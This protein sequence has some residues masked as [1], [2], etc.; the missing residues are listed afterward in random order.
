VSR[1]AVFSVL[2]W[3]FQLVREW[4]DEAGHEIVMLVTRPDPRNDPGLSNRVTSLASRD[5]LIMITPRVT[6]SRSALLE[7][8]IDL[9]LIFAYNH[10]PESVAAAP[11]HGTVN[12]HPALLPD[13]RGA[14]A[15]R[16]LFEGEQRIGATLHHVVEEF[17]AGP[18]LAQS[19]CD[20]PAVVD[21][22]SVRTA[23]SGT[24]SAV[25]RDGVP[26][27]LADEPGGAQPPATAKVSTPFREDEL[28]LT[29]NI[30]ARLLQARITALMMGGR[31]PRACI[32]E[33]VQ[34]IRGVRVLD[35]LES[36]APGVVHAT[37][38]RAIV[39]VADAVVEVDIGRL[40]Y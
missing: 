1:L 12:M 14:N 4:A 31:Q 15:N 18:I 13:Y 11:V 5:T 40:P 36:H 24:M 23:W 39:G 27:A 33:E 17:D 28:E 34:P 7:H 25:L 21:P 8:D 19:G 30:P 16:A 35:G 6:D 38:R 9:G 2:P 22:D 10:I 20:V 3:G 37:S 29:W 32:G 26:K